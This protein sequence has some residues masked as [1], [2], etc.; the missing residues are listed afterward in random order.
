MELIKETRS[1]G[2]VLR[3]RGYSNSYGPDHYGDTF[4]EE[5][6]TGSVKG[7]KKHFEDEIAECNHR[8]GR[9]KS[10]TGCY[11][12]S[13]D[14]FR[15]IT[16]RRR[17][18]TIYSNQMVELGPRSSDK[19]YI[20]STVESEKGGIE[21]LEAEQ[22]ECISKIRGKEQPPNHIDDKENMKYHR[23]S[24][25]FDSSY[26]RKKIFPSV[27]IQSGSEERNVLRN[28]KPRR[29]MRLREANYMD[30][31]T[32]QRRKSIAST[33]LSIE[34]SLDSSGNIRAYA[35]GCTK[36]V[37]YDLGNLHICSDSHQS[38]VIKELNSV[39]LLK[40]SRRMTDGNISDNTVLSSKSTNTEN[41]DLQSNSSV[42]KKRNTLSSRKSVKE[43]F[44]SVYIIDDEDNVIVPFGSY[45]YDADRTL[46]PCYTSEEQWIPPSSSKCESDSSMFS[47]ITTRGRE[48][49]A[50]DE[51]NESTAA[52]S[53][54]NNRRKPLRTSR[55]YSQRKSKCLSRHADGQ[56]LEHKC[57][58]ATNLH[59][60]EAISDNFENG[61]S[62][63]HD[64]STLSRR[65]CDELNQTFI[66]DEPVICDCY[67]VTGE[68]DEIVLATIV[69][70]EISQI[71]GIESFLLG[72]KHKTDGGRNKASRRRK[73]STSSFRKPPVKSSGTSTG[74][75][76]KVCSN[77][78]TI[79]E[80]PKVTPN[81]AGGLNPSD[82]I[83]C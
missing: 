45:E 58:V 26:N 46:S 56:L 8:R 36:W 23:H 80:K 29:S 15:N 70:S 48:S 6:A 49:Y 44:S 83:L 17:S 68:K 40:K 2:K 3:L 43:D 71:G 78:E 32:A 55:T 38:H 12:K 21:H 9:R 59:R 11:Q 57:Q 67:S 66:D 61:T 22:I 76:Q 69:D 77:L 74:N 50:C 20:E 10:S 34:D 25:S 31:N 27:D 7:L 37:R 75:P 18:D 51:I 35:E 79:F 82:S 53:N 52:N 41:T 62:K 24:L 64:S 19:G 47:N 33:D 54:N 14:H 16:T 60:D 30:T 39:T 81:Y 1:P 42:T 63:L 13:K 5:Y 65:V 73:K 72:D 28:N 4:A